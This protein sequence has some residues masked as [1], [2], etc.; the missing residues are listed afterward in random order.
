MKILNLN[1]TGFIQPC[2]LHSLENQK[3]SSRLEKPCLSSQSSLSLLLH[4]SSFVLHL[5]SNCMRH[6][7]RLWQPY[8]PTHQLQPLNSSPQ[9]V[10]KQ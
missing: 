7:L 3:R 8:Q 4:S 9:T 2:Q 1:C 5:K 10:R 6:N